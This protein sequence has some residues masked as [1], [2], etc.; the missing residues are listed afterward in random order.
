MVLGLI[1]TRKVLYLLGKDTWG[2]WAASGSLLS[3]AGLAD[4][5]ALRILPWVIADAD[6]KKDGDRIR[7]ALSAG[8]PFACAT[9]FTYAA[10]A[11][12]LWHF[13][14]ALLQLSAADQFALRG[15]VLAVVGL[16]AATFPLRLFT[17][18][19]TG[20]Q[21]A[22]F[23]GAAGLVEVVESSLLTYLLAWR[24]FGLYSLAIGTALPPTL[25][26]IAAFFR[27][28][29][30]FRTFVRGWSRP[31]PK[32]MKML[33]TDGFGTWLASVGFQLAAAA[34]PVI[35]SNAGLRVAVA[36]FVISSRIPTM[37]TQFAWILPDAALVGLA[38]LNA[39]ASRER[40]REVVIAIFRL[41][42]IL[43]GVVASAVLAA[44]AGFVRIWVGGD[45]FLGVLLNALF[46]LNAVL[47]TALH[48]LATVAGVF[49]RRLTIG[50]VFV[51][52]GLLHL[53]LG[54]FLSRQIGVYG[55]AA[56]TFLSGA[57][58]AL[59]VGLRLLNEQVGLR[60]RELL[61]RVFWPW[62]RRFTPLAALA[63]LIG[64]RGAATSFVLLVLECCAFGIIYLFWMK[65]LYVGLP[66]GPRL[67]IWLAKLHLLPS[68][69]P[70]GPA[71]N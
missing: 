35:L 28:N 42:L 55:I 24:G 4:L 29:I 47:M 11:L 13:Y 48:G 58:T 41:D 66:L 27:A 9:G 64:Y 49:G 6:G 7:A 23:L 36:A 26:A 70:A 51:V 34:D 59:P 32:F 44:N 62:L 17:A 63:F 50:I 40:V 68:G 57:L 5:G 69:D 31:A 20:L 10:L 2:M 21:D 25:T 56:A 61:A 30:S 22:T 60:T 71:Q 18:L 45:L 3:Y 53:A 16:T 37:L 33:A 67:T 15:P 19:L 12:A 52:N 46:A 39:E 1:V 54:F 38:Q 14:P 43:A 65:P 8:L